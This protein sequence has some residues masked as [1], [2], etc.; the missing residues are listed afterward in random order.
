MLSAPLVISQSVLQLNP[1]IDRAAAAS[2]GP[3]TVTAFELGVRL[4]L[5][6]S[7]LV[8]GVIVAPLVATWSHRLT[9]GGWEDVTRSFARVVTVVVVVLLPVVVV[10]FLLRTHLVTIAYHSHAYPASAV[11]ETA[12]VFGTLVI[13]L[14][15]QVLIVP[16]ATLFIIR[17][18]TVFP[19]KV[20]IANCVI[21]AIL[22][23]L[24]RGPLGVTGIALSTTMT[25]TVLCAVY[26]RA[27][28]R[29]WGS[30]GCEGVWRPMAISGAACVA[31]AI[32]GVVITRLLGPA[33][34]REQAIIGAAAV[35]LAAAAIY[36]SVI[37]AARAGWLSR[38]LDASKSTWLASAATATDA[39][40]R[41]PA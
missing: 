5:A 12:D 9:A 23:V 2:L 15:P 39:V 11:A 27:A 25:L 26:L 21:N 36:G 32:A 41:P 8:A 6:A 18:N 17:K 30:L 20:G 4:F 16:V 29:R 40:G 38:L 28:R 33:A 34:S 14:I 7:T 35:V 24:L 13:A 1:L 10:G 22:D 37:G 3:G 19:M 31:I